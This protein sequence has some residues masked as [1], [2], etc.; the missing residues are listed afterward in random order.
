M[1]FPRSMIF[2]YC[3][4]ILLIVICLQ[5][6]EQDINQYRSL[7]TRRQSKTSLFY[8][9]FWSSITFIWYVCSSN[10]SRVKYEHILIF[11]F[12]IPWKVQGK[13]FS[14]SDARPLWAYPIRRVYVAYS[15]TKSMHTRDLASN[16]KGKCI[17]VLIALNDRITS[18]IAGHVG[19]QDKI[20]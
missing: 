1:F 3:V 7:F 13:A 6:S 18:Y 19:G 11:F 9:Y 16:A 2:R 5:F 4:M 8:F 15:R 12:S 14:Q 20:S 10:K 17:F